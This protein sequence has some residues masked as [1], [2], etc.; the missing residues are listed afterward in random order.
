MAEILQAHEVRTRLGVKPEGRFPAE[1]WF[2]RRTPTTGLYPKHVVLVKRN[3][4]TG[5]IVREYDLSDLR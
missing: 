4:E 2:V 1:G 3:V 5:R